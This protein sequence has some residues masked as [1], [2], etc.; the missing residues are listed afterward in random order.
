MDPEE[1]IIDQDMDMGAET[2]PPEAEL[3]GEEPLPPE[4]GDGAVSETAPANPFADRLKSRFPDREFENDDQMQ[5]ALVEYLDELEQNDKMTREA[6]E[7]LVQVLQDVP[8]LTAM[9]RDIA[10]GASFT[11]ALS[12]HVDLDELTP[13]EGDPDYEAWGQNMEQRKKTRAEKQSR[14]KAL[15]ENIKMSLS[16]IEAFADENG[17]E[18]ADVKSFI[19]TVNDF[20]G[21]IVDGKITKKT[22][23]KLKKAIDYDMD[24]DAAVKQG[25]VAGKN[26]KIEKTK[27][28]EKKKATGDGLP[29]LTTQGAKDIAP[30]QEVK[31]D[32]WAETIE[33]EKSRQKLV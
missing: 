4:M 6:N 29:N 12:R 14:Q 25:E 2:Q 3:M 7:K 28:A 31:T 11:E 8:E 27:M 18:E 30:K 22:L 23:A 32:D 20:V 17:M 19:G 10:Q 21:E 16:E 15:D 13:V 1:D 26:A 33:R 5:E 24:V 9:I